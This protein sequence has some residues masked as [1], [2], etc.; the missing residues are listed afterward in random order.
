MKGKKWIILGIILIAIIVGVI[1]Y[2]ALNG[3]GNREIQLRDDDIS[4]ASASVDDNGREMNPE[5]KNEDA[6]EADAAEKVGKSTGENDMVVGATGSGNGS[7]TEN[8]GNDSGG[9]D[10]NG[11]NNGSQGLVV[12]DPDEMDNDPST[13]TVI[14]S[15]GQA[16]TSTDNGG[17]GD[18]ADNSDVSEGGDTSNGSGGDT[19]NENAYTLM[20]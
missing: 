2:I 3:R 14:G 6:E 19:N 13:T 17:A 7:N 11:N 9:T 1:L 5:P 18:D 16:D 15:P 20:K 4:A 12:G 8:G 10:T